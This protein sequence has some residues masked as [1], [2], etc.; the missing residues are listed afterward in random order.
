MNGDHDC[1][2]PGEGG[3]RVSMKKKLMGGNSFP[4]GGIF[5]MWAQSFLSISPCAGSLSRY[6]VRG[7]FS[8]APPHDNFFAG[9]PIIVVTFFFTSQIFIF[10][11]IVEVSI[12]L[13]NLFFLFLGWG[14]GR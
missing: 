9:A 6:V 10:F 1:R 5:S 11:Q 13:G 12:F 8:L 2:S 7:I 14:G 4:Y 3:G